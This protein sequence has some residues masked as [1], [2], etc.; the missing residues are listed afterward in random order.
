[1]VGS[2]GAALQAALNRDARLLLGG[3]LEAGLSYRLANDEERALFERLGTV[4]EV[5]EVMGH[6]IVGDESVFLSLRAV[7]A[8]YPLVGSVTVNEPQTPGAS[9]GE[10]LALRDGAY[11]IVASSL[12]FDRLGLAIGDRLTID[13]AEF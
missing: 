5:V 7:D 1:I 9:L 10:L 2:V 13:A 11:G 4:A 12:L 6:G 3:D 8:N